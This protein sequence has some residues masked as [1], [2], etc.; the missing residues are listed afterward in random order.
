MASVFYGGAQRTQPIRGYWNQATFL[1]LLFGCYALPFH[2]FAYYNLHLNYLFQTT[3]IDAVAQV[4][5][6]DVEHDKHQDFYVLDYVYSDSGNVPHGG[7]VTVTY[8]DWNQIP[9]GA[10]VPI[11]Y[12]HDYPERSIAKGASVLYTWGTTLFWVGSFFSAIASP[13]LIFG[14]YTGWRNASIRRT[15][16]NA[17]GF[18]TEVVT[19]QV[20]TKSGMSTLYNLHYTFTDILGNA[21]NGEAKVTT[22]TGLQW[23]QRLVQGNNQIEVMYAQSNPNA[24]ILLDV[25]QMPT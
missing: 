24:H 19:R 12:L 25:Q 23:Q 13:L 4:T 11:V 6:H 8:S 14:G 1:G 16:R 7:N 2:Y 10:N 15:G 20:R 9:N 21:Y 17:T 22:T 18:V 3:G 5:M